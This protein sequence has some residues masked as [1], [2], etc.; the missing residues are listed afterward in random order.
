MMYMGLGQDQ[1]TLE[2]MDNYN[3]LILN[4]LGAKYVL[5]ET[6]S[7]VT[8][9]ENNVDAMKQRRERRKSEYE[10]FNALRAKLDPED[11]FLSD[12]VAKSFLP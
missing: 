1:E 9:T 11:K 6:L 12:A 4:S 2:A 8:V 5:D 3:T 7:K 10:K